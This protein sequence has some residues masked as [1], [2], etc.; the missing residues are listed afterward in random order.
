MKPN[1]IFCL[2]VVMIGFVW[3]VC[4]VPLFMPKIKK[5][6]STPFMWLCFGISMIIG[7]ALIVLGAKLSF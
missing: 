3:N 6:S 5:S 7:G 1:F 4:I 2:I